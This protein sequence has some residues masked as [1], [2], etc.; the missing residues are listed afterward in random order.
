MA[1]VSGEVD[2][3]DAGVLGTELEA[4]RYGFLMAIASKSIFRKSISVLERPE[5]LPFFPLGIPR[6]GLPSSDC[7]A[8]TR[9]VR[10]SPSQSSVLRSG[11]MDQKM[12]SGLHT[13]IF[14]RV[15]S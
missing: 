2:C 12:K 13:V 10:Y 14:G 8:T 11:Y 3:E 5:G 9:S 6:N 15:D 1:R 7:Y 4:L